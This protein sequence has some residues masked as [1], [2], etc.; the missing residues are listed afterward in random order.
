MCA[1]EDGH[2]RRSVPLQPCPRS[3]SR[4]Q[5]TSLRAPMGV[6]CKFRAPFHKVLIDMGKNSASGFLICMW[7][8]RTRSRS[9]SSWSRLVSLQHR[10][11]VLFEG[12]LLQAFISL[13]RHLSLRIVTSGVTSA[14]SPLWCPTCPGRRFLFLCS[15][16]SLQLTQ[17]VGSASSRPGISVFA[18][19]LLPTSSATW[20]APCIQLCHMRS[21]HHP[22]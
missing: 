21:F 15:V 2:V 19:V 22:S 14:S 13:A 20:H 8:V 5:P 1:R 18:A 6:V 7:H 4:H 10:L 3:S 9:W 12:R 11:S 16:S 17:L